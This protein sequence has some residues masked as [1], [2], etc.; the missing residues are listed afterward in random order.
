MQAL[1]NSKDI[2]DN[3]LFCKIYLWILLCTLS[4]SS[5]SF[6]TAAHTTG[7]GPSTSNLPF[8]EIEKRYAVK[9]LL[10]AGNKC[11][12]Q[13]EYQKAF[14]Y[15]EKT[16]EEGILINAVEAVEAN[17][18]M[19]WCYREGVGRA[20]DLKEANSYA[21]RADFCRR[22]SDPD[23]NL[24]KLLASYGKSPGNW[25][26]L[27]I[28]GG[29]YIN[30]GYWK[31]IAEEEKK[32]RVDDCVLTL[33]DRIQSGKDLYGEIIKLLDIKPD[34]VILEVGCGRGAGIYDFFCQSGKDSFKSLIGID[35]NREQ[36]ECSKKLIGDSGEKIKLL[37]SK[38]DNIPLESGSIDKIYSVEIVQHF[39]P[40]LMNQFARQVKK[41][42]K[43]GGRLVFTSY[44][45]VNDEVEMNHR[46]ELDRLF[47]CREK[48]L[49]Y[50][51]SPSEI[52]RYFIAAGFKKDKIKHVS[53]G[54]DVFWGFDKWA[55]QH[56]NKA[57]FTNSFYKAYKAKYIDYYIFT[58]EN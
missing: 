45:L 55:K 32:R 35:I 6:A 27:P 25:G 5:T 33:E 2:Q 30:Y 15:W 29:G 22:M 43:D 36:I 34:D 56:T 3:K 58:I 18:R 21:Q 13:H 7:T 46:A 37:C 20:V 42:L 10:A 40:C 41:L 49:E 52:E 47:P 9:R 14:E 39:S 8:N 48:G 31:N 26:D 28:F 4:V 23:L 50:H 24:E 54:K 57:E 11:L 16:D 53:I 19:S 38:A 1:Y 12:N 51:F 17:L 44:F